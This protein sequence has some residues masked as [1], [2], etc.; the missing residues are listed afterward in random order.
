[1]L[2]SSGLLGTF[3][4]LSHYA[5]H[6]FLISGESLCDKRSGRATASLYYLVQGH[7]EFQTPTGRVWVQS[8]DL[9]YIP[10]RQR[11][12][13][14]WKGE[15]NIL[16]YGID[17]KF[18]LKS[19]FGAVPGETDLYDSFVLQK[20]P[21]TVLEHPQETFEQLHT[22]YCD[23]AHNGL[24]AVIAFHHIFLQLLPALDKTRIRLLD[25]ATEKAAVY[26]EDH[27]TENFYVEELAEMCGLSP[28]GFYNAFKKHTGMTPVEYK[29]CARIRLAQKM[30][31][32]NNSAEEIA[33]ALNFSSPAYFRKVFHS[34]TGMLPS[35]YKKNALGYRPK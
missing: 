5:V 7:T 21:S 32:Q 2:D 13:A 29:N 1:M 17:F 23:P 14:V 10:R 3:F 8:G 4:S 11:Y 30:I 31:L 6:K 35:V 16:F 25:N 18:E 26:I 9:L 22:L 34:V 33:A 27:C 19:E 20:L 24:Q 28:A 12:T 15:P